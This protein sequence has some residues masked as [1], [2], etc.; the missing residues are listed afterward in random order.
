M[1][2]IYA[3]SR[4]F[5]DRWAARHP[6][7]AVTITYTTSGPEH[8]RRYICTYTLDGTISLVGDEMTSMADP[9]ESAATK[10]WRV[11][12]LHELSFSLT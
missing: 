12:W 10:A 8:N 3:N 5:V 9:K 2:G 7:W 4:Q 6:Q 1:G 11:C